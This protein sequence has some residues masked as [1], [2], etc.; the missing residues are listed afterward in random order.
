M[1]IWRKRDVFLI[2]LPAL[3]A[4][5]LAL[6]PT[7]KYGVPLTWDIYYHIHN[8]TLYMEKGIVFWDPLTY[9]PYGRPIYYPPLFHIM[10]VFLTKITGLGF[11]TVSRFIQ[12]VFAFLIVL[13]FSYVSGKLYGPL[14]GFLTGI[15]LFSSLFFI[16]MMSPIPESLAMISIPILVYGYYK[17]MESC[18]RLYPVLTGLLLGLMLMTHLLSAS[19]IL[20]VLTLSTMALYIGRY[21]IR[22]GNLLIILGS[23]L[24]VASVW[25]APL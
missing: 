13:S 2:I 4:F 18:S 6:I 12:P 8:A 14:A 7:L 21:D 20:A 5:F 24:L 10:L 25:Y 9:A 11:F 1:D 15:F 19:I 3:F 16:R 17:S 23:G 22:P